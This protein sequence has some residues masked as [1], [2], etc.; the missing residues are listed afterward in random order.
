MRI[1]VID[2]PGHAFA[3]QLCRTLARRGH[4]VMLS[5]YAEFPGPKGPLS[6]RDDDPATL[7]IHPVVLGEPF[8]KYNFF[9]RRQQELE[10]GKRFGKLVEEF[11]P[12]VVA[13]CT[14]PIDTQT[15]IMHSIQRTRSAAIF[16]L[17][18]IISIAMREILGRKMP[19]FGHAVAV[20]YRQ[21][22]ARLFRASDAIVAI[23]EDFFNALA[24]LQ[25]D[26]RKCHVIP[27]WAPLPDIPVK[28]KDNEWARE[29][30][31]ADK[32][33]ILYSGTLG[34]KHNPETLAALAENLRDLPDARVV[35]VSEGLGTDYLTRVKTE[36]RLDNLILFPFQPAALL[37]QI[38]GSADILTGFIEPEAG[39][40][41]VP[42]KL[43]SYFCASR[44]VLGGIVKGN[45]AAREMRRY[46]LGIVVE[47][48]DTTEYFAAVR[49]LLSDPDLRDVYG[50]KARRYAD[51]N[52]DIEKIT[53][54][55]LTIFETA[56]SHQAES[57]VPTRSAAYRS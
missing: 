19:G 52:F 26:P 20:Y 57:D 16:W 10:I 3:I 41:S 1:A 2:Y 27:N 15:E 47:P 37:P 36:R 8:R 46:D 28:P 25:L 42:S 43:L 51:E 6:P 5:Y 13:A 29:H 53:S 39:L 48:N 12:N 31:L 14:V 49:K 18:D 24:N 30:E 34:L 45:A 44:A 7:S 21:R 33:V 55:F 56:I 4:V 17:Q 9:K 23:S 40:Y 11:K 50:R 35:V 32:A 54:R 22:E 38:L